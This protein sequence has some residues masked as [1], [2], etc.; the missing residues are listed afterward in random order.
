MI[1]WIITGSVLSFFLLI[2]SVPV[3]FHFTW[4]TGQELRASLHILFLRFRFFPEKAA[5]ETARDTKKA[6]K[7]EEKKKEL[8]E[9]GYLKKVK[10]WQKTAGVVWDIVKATRR[11]LAWL[12]RRTVFYRIR[13]SLVVGGEDAHVT[14]MRYGQMMAAVSAGVDIL[15][16]LFSLRR[17]RIH[18]TPDFTRETLD[19][20]VGFRVRIQPLVVLVT[21]GWAGLRWLRENKR[22]KKQRIKGGNQHEPR[23]SH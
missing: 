19:A 17:P 6:L 12:L 9:Q 13:V 16:N 11:P 2:F 5:E 18:I 21:A 10:G 7:K 1:G 15:Q 22:N 14:A 20:N 4:G 23:T 3:R 8:E